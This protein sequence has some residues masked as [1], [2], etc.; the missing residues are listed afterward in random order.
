MN[1]RQLPCR[2]LK[3]ADESFPQGGLFSFFCI[4]TLLIFS[5]ELLS[6]FLHIQPSCLLSILSVLLSVLG[7]A[8]G[9]Y[10]TELGQSCTVSTEGAEHSKGTLLIDTE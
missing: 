5:S 1:Y 9:L 4:L 6:L 8:E 3:Y 7:V 10:E 2:S